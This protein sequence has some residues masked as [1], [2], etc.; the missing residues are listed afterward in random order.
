MK[1]WL[2]SISSRFQTL[3]LLVKK[4]KN[5]NIFITTYDWEKLVCV[6]LLRCWAPW[7]IHI[8]IPLH[9]DMLIPASFLH[10]FYRDSFRN[11][12]FLNWQAFQA[13]R[14][15]LMTVSNHDGNGKLTDQPTTITYN[16]KN[17]V[18]INFSCQTRAI[19]FWRKCKTG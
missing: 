5:Q 16:K 18:I 10:L 4:K 9:V 14:H 12:R 13:K 17:V 19:N 2:Q 3:S 8:Y 11:D 6:Y 1:T 7:W 15:H